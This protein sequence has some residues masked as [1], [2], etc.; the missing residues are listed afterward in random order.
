MT[1]RTG[2][3][4]DVHP[5]VANKPLVLGGVNI[6]FDLGLQGHSD[7]DVLIHSIID[8][9]LGG[10]ALGDIGT[11]FPSNDIK[12]R[13]IV[14]T[15]LLTETLTILEKNDWY[16]IFVDATIIAERPV[17][18]A[19]TNTI[20]HNLAK[21]IGLDDSSVSIKSKTTNGLGFIGKGDGAAAITIVT[22]ESNQ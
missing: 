3:G 6:P 21:T 8:A 10:A 13:N 11:Y 18:S 5:L 19:F 2:I 16:P 12:F 9:M 17:L 22:I 7:G 20:K 4:F 1:T 14:S 15:I